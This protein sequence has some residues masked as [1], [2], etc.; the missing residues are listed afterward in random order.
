MLF[1]LGYVAQECPNLMATGKSFKSK[2][3]YLKDDVMNKGVWISKYILLHFNM[4]LIIYEN[5]KLHNLEDYDRIVWGDKLG[6]KS[7]STCGKSTWWVFQLRRKFEQLKMM[8]F[9]DI[10]KDIL[11]S[12]SSLL[13]FSFSNICRQGCFSWCLYQESKIFFS[14]ASL[15]EICCTRFL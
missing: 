4:I 8:Y 11:L 9:K 13:S 3:K 1:L 5:D 2:F 10:I 6:K 14:V 12:S 15:D 7:K